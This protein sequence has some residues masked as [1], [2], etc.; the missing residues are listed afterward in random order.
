MFHNMRGHLGFRFRGGIGCCDDGSPTFEQ[1]VR[2]RCKHADCTWWITRR[3][4][5]DAIKTD[6]RKEARFSLLT[7]TPKGKR[8][9]ESSGWQSYLARSDVSKV[10]NYR[11]EDTVTARGWYEGFG[12]ANA[13]INQPY[14]APGPRVRGVWRPRVRMQSGAGGL[15]VTSHSVHVD[16]SFHDGKAGVV[17]ERGPGSYDGVLR[18]NTRRLKN[19]LHRLVLITHARQIRPNDNVLDGTNSGVLSVP[20]FVRN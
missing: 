2:L 6:G 12:Y 3:I 8:M 7:R 19:G 14:R 5:T 17:V 18:I 16:P 10:Q 15:P 4:D 1:P 11:D 13:S 9:Y 20:F